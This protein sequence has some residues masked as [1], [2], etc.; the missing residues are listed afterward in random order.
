MDVQNLAIVNY[1]YS[2]VS[3]IILDLK[4]EYD[5][6][7]VN[8]FQSLPIEVKLLCEINN[9]YE[10]VTNNLLEINCSSNFYLYKNQIKTIIFYLK[11]QLENYEKICLGV[12][13]LI[14]SEL[15]FES[16]AHDPIAYNSAKVYKRFRMQRYKYVRQLNYDYS[17]N[18]SIVF[19]FY[20]LIKHLLRELDMFSKYIDSIEFMHF[21][22][23]SNSHKDHVNKGI[24]RIELP[25]NILMAVLIFC[26]DAHSLKDENDKVLNAVDVAKIFNSHFIY[27]NSFGESYSESTIRKML[28]MKFDKHLRD[29][30]IHLLYNYL[31]QAFGFQKIKKYRNPFKSKQ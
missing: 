9:D 3:D 18:V 22:N 20:S 10:I 12:I 11:K 30:Q 28:S 13:A 24:S 1:L 29:K 7:N 23:V 4:R 8:Y 17:E 26:I 6:S 21:E 15:N 5:D 27:K 25:G 2:P 16:Y 19:L 14:N 31:S